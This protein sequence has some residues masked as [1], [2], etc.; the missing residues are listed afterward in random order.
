MMPPAP[1]RFRCPALLF[2][3]SVAKPLSLCAQLERRARKRQSR[4]EA[5]SAAPRGHDAGDARV[6]MILLSR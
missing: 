1:R 5:E 2:V 6:E 4:T 3:L